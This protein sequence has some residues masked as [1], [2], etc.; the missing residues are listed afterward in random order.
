MSEA[1]P[2]VPR[3]ERRLPVAFAVGQLLVLLVLTRES[4][5]LAVALA[6]G[7]LALV[8]V[9]GLVR[10]GDPVRAVATFATLSVAGAAALWLALGAADALWLVALGLV[11][12][13]AAL[14]YGL[15]RYERVALGLVTDGGVDG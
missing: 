14:A 2:S 5:P 11:L 10:T 13:V 15:H 9:A 8:L 12:A 3:W 4:G 7:A 6:E 1:R